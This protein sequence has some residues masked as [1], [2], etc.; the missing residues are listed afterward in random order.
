[1]ENVQHD[2]FLEV[3]RFRKLPL[4]QLGDLIHDSFI[5]LNTAQVKFEALFSEKKV[6][7]HGLAVKYISLSVYNKNTPLT[8]LYKIAGEIADILEMENPLE[9]FCTHWGQNKYLGFYHVSNLTFLP[10]VHSYS[11][12]E[13]TFSKAELVSVFDERISYRQLHLCK[14]FDDLNHRLSFLEKEDED[15]MLSN[16]RRMKMLL[17]SRDYEKLKTLVLS[18]QKMLVLERDLFS[19]DFMDDEPNDPIDG[20][21]NAIV[22]TFFLKNSLVNE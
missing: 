11:S 5:W 17:M 2:G 15:I 10:L 16:I 22:S 13:K 6:A 18:I 7:V 9:L 12:L 20:V 1:M 14:Y 8:D 19:S 21:F 3:V 4:A